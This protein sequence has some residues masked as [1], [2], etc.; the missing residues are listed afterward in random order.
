MH[1]QAHKHIS[2]H[3]STRTHARAHTQ[4]HARTSTQAYTHALAHTHAQARTSTH[5]RTLHSCQ[6]SRGSARFRVPGRRRTASGQAGTGSPR[7]G[8]PRLP[9]FAAVTL[10]TLSFTGDFPS[11]RWITPR[12]PAPQVKAAVAAAVRVT[13][14]TDSESPGPAA[15]AGAALAPG[16]P[17]RGLRADWRGHLKRRLGG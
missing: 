13:S 6:C 9:L 5:A 15:T 14:L 16:G 2:T 1:A 11:R 3:T 7:R 8:I 17:A 4:K 12:L 10:G